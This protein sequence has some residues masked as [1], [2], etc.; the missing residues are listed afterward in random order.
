MT[1]T[2]ALADPMVQALMSADGV[3]VPQ[4]EADLREL[5]GDLER[6]DRSRQSTSAGRLPRR[7][8]DAVPVCPVEYGPANGRLTEEA[9]RRG[10][11]R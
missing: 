4:L 10:C 3:D 2:E 11:L 5:A 7:I 9:M 8:A 1:L 6:R